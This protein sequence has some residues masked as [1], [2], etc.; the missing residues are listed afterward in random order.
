MELFGLVGVGSYCLAA[1]SFGLY[2]QLRRRLALGLA[3]PLRVNR[4]LLWSLAASA[5]ATQYA[6][7]L[8]L[9]MATGRTLAVGAETLFVSAL[10]L[11]AAATMVLAFLPPRAYRR[12]IESTPSTP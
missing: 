4:G 7:S 3:E 9:L 2:R 8:S 12:H 1:A 5:I 6:F 10:G 11:A